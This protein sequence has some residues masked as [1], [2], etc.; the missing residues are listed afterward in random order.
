MTAL[1]K[2]KNENIISFEKFDEEYQRHSNKEID[3]VLNF[4]RSVNR[5][6][7]GITFPKDKVTKESISVLLTRNSNKFGAI[8]IP[9]NTIV[10]NLVKNIIQELQTRTNLKGFKIY[11]LTR[12]INNPLN[13]KLTNKELL[14]APYFLLL[15]LYALQNHIFDINEIT[16]NQAITYEKVLNLI[17]LDEL[18]KLLRK[19]VYFEDHLTEQRLEKQVLIYLLDRLS[20]SYLLTH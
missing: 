13:D 10:E 19:Y 3:D 1:K 16:V 12:I 9:N 11:N 5:W 17:D 20:G 4:K 18:T 14:Q 6:M 2:A 15:Q 8:V 7:N